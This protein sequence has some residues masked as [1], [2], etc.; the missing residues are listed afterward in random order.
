MTG[1]AVVGPSPIA[2]YRGW[3]GGIVS[4]DAQH[5][6]RL[7]QPG[8]AFDHVVTVALQQI[9]FILTGGAGMYLG[10]W[11]GAAETTRRF[12]PC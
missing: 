8:L 3:V 9:P 4:V 11:P 2:A 6:S 7:R 10:R 5:R 12:V 1:L